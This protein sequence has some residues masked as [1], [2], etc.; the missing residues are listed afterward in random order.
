MKLCRQHLKFA[1]VFLVSGLWF[2]TGLAETSDWRKTLADGVAKVELL[3]PQQVGLYVRDLQTGES[4]GHRS[5]ET[6]Y[7][8][9]G[10]KVPIAMEILRQIDHGQ[11]SLD[12]KVTLQTTDFLDGAGETNFQ[13]PGSHLTLRYL[14]EQMLIHSDNTASD[15]LIRA[16]GLENINRNLG[17]LVPTGF[18]RITTLADVRRLAFSQFH[19]KANELTNAQ[20][21]KIR[22]THGENARIHEL[23]A[24]L[25]IRLDKLKCRTQDQAFAAYYEQHLNSASL[26]GY[27][28]LLEKI[29]KKTP[30]KAETHA[31]LVDTMSRVETGKKRIR[32][33]LPSGF[34][35]AHK[36]GTQHARLCDFG[37][38]WDKSHTPAHQVVITSCVR[39]VQ[40]LSKSESAL[41]LL[42]R[43]VY[44]SGVFSHNP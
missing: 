8:A 43:A 1:G 16:A 19:P 22:R 32:A 25:H 9:S 39:N 4:F 6:W 34:Q 23:A 5:E 24:L 29:F 33:A 35:W 27:A 18:T 21:L 36:T 13:K 37:V 38:A 10:V 17:E 30:L 40:S 2:S 41:K 42:G 7:V 31:F 28:D 20:I 44:A 15:L 12:Q 11:L 26:S 14:L 3:Y